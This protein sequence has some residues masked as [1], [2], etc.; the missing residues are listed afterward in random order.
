MDAHHNFFFDIPDNVQNVAIGLSGGGDS[1][2]LAHMMC[3]WAKDSNR[4]IHLLSVNHNLREDSLAEAETV[5]RWVSDFPNATHVILNWEFESKPDTAVMERARNARY[6]L[7]AD[8][9]AKNDIETLAIAHHGDDNVETFLFRLA[10]GSGLDGLTGM[11]EWG[12]FK[13]V[14][15]YRPLLGYSHDELIKYCEQ[16]NLNWIEDPSNSNEKYARPRLRNALLNEGLDTRRF[17]KTLERL[18]RGQQAL[19]WMMN[20]AYQECVTGNKIDFGTLVKKP[21]DIQIRVLQQCL[22]IVGAT[23]SGYPPKLERIEAIIE[24]LKPNKSATLHGCLISLSK[25]GMTLEIK[26]S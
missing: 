15:I 9:C 5:A 6:E 7:M 18:A 3:Q 13:G 8:Y 25:D 24:T 17:T 16:Y 20:E 11:N 21:L 19:D 26:A 2:A 14:N 10:K 22:S 1:M 23:E 12:V 4:H